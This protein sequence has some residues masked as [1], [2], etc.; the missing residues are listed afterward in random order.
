M[1]R[2]CQKCG[3]YRPLD[4][5][6]PDPDPELWDT[7]TEVVSD[8]LNPSD[9][10]SGTGYAA[11]GQGI[12]SPTAAVAMNATDSPTGRV[13]GHMPQTSVDAAQSFNARSHRAL[14]YAALV[15]AEASGLTSR[16]IAKLLPVDRD[17]HPQNSNRS[18]SRLGELWEEKLATVKRERG[19]CVLGGCSPHAKP[20]LIHKPQEPCA[21]HGKPLR[22]DGAAIWVAL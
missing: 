4:H 9:E 14:A 10:I 13:P 12:V 8:L 21:M 3:E 11:G 22:R 18:A 17:G 6:H 5:E 15:D 16:E 19:Q 2:W 1:D 20:S 7:V